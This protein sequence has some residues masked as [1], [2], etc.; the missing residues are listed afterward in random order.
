MG[1]KAKAETGEVRSG[2]EWG[3]KEDQYLESGVSDS[4]NDFAVDF[5]LTGKILDI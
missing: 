2:K 1:E 4:E 3:L 5:G